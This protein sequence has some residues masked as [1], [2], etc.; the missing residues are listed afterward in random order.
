[1]WQFQA[2][3]GK[4]ILSLQQQIKANDMLSVTFINAVKIEYFGQKATKNQVGIIK[5]KSSCWW[6]EVNYKENISPVYH[7]GI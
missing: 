7:L 5:I 2:D 4:N 3:R 1:M 6:N